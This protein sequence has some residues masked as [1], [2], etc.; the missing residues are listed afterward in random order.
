[1]NCIVDQCV[2]RYIHSNMIFYTTFPEN[3]CN[4]NVGHY[5]SDFNW[6]SW[7]SKCVTIIYIYFVLCIY[8]IVMPIPHQVLSVKYFLIICHKISYNFFSQ[9][10]PKLGHT[11]SHK[12]QTIG[13]N[14][15]IMCSLEEG[16]LPV[17]FEW[18][19]NGQTLKPSPDV[20]YK[21]ENSKK[22]STFSIDEIK[23]SDSGN[24]TCVVQNGFGGDRHTVLLSIKGLLIHNLL[25][26]WYYPI[27]N[28]KIQWFLFIINNYHT[29]MCQI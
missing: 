29:V 5:L 4:I 1:M 14:F 24:Y 23:I 9:I 13:S 28:F 3:I 27:F 2:A 6:V 8:F 21:I 26:P 17:F 20:S 10:V 12:T 16:S 22:F 11:V 7:V 25:L 15:H 19:R 18:S